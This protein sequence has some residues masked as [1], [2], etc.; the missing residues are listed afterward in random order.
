[1]SPAGA[2]A[3]GDRDA[4]CFDLGWTNPFDPG[5]AF[6][7]AASVQED[8][9]YVHSQGH[10]RA[11]PHP[12]IN[13]LSA[14][15]QPPPAL[16]Q[17]GIAPI[18]R[19]PLLRSS[20]RTPPLASSA[21]WQPHHSITL[22]NC[23]ELSKQRAAD[24]FD[25][26]LGPFPPIWNTPQSGNGP[27]DLSPLSANAHRTGGGRAVC[28]QSQVMTAGSPSSGP[29]VADEGVAYDIGSADSRFAFA[30]SHADH[31][32]QYSAGGIYSVSGCS[33]T[34]GIPPFL[35]ES[36]FATTRPAKRKADIGLDV[37]TAVKQARTQ[38][39]EEADWWDPATPANA[40]D[41]E[42]HSSSSGAARVEANVLRLPPD[43]VFAAHPSDLTVFRIMRASEA[44]QSGYEVYV[45]QQS[46]ARCG[47]DGRNPSDEASSQTAGHLFPFTPDFSAAPSSAMATDSRQ[48]RS[49][50]VSSLSS[51]SSD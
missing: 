11:L 38:G 50:S 22:H 25:A 39:P 2:A 40:D 36:R 49:A 12:T 1:M 8:V 43:M 24:D 9:E 16:G 4:D 15:L 51:L 35:D 41:N 42:A 6:G 44:I 10:L 33:L 46:C 48:H 47:A 30:P 45:L 20:V 18:H 31:H 19:A 26:A 3:F 32:L 14:S 23:F 7:S 27:F 28:R 29:R 34:Q 17:P 21:P 13:S 5:N 37:D